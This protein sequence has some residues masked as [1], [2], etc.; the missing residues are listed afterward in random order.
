MSAE[1]RENEMDIEWVKPPHG[2]TK[3]KLKDGERVL[4]GDRLKAMFRAKL[5]KKRM[6]RE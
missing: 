1:D 2:D 4:S 6:P 3:A 5:Q